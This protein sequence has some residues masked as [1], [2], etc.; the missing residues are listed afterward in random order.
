MCFFGCARR[1]GCEVRPCRGVIYWPMLSAAETEALWLSLAVAARSVALDLPFAVLVAWLL[2]RTRFP[3]RTLFD[4]F[5]HLPLVLPP[6]V[7]GCLLLVLFGVRGPHRRLAARHLRHPARVHQHRR[8]AR[9][10]GH[11]VPA[12]GA[13]HP[14]LARGRRPRAGGR[15]AHARRRPARPLRHHHPAADG[16]RHPGR[17]R[18]RLR[19][20]ARRIRRGHHLRL[21]HPRRD[22][23]AAA[24]AVHRAADAGRRCDGRAARAVSFSLGLAGLLFRNF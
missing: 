20:G 4:A 3:G 17:R 9:H 16:A 6:V 24:G 12:D 23:H 7:V 21:Q 5:V 2:T 1:S 19:R 18:H 10:G 13:R 15:R 8:R 14:H 11:V 22:A